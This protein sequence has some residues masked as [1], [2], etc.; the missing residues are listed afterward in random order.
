MKINAYIYIHIIINK[1][2]Y[3]LKIIAMSNIMIWMGWCGLTI[4]K[5]KEKDKE[6]NLG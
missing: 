3:N 5:W 4:Q 2:K 6:D 1:D